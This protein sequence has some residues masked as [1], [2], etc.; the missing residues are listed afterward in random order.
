MTNFWVLCHVT[1]HQ[2]FLL[3]LH[4]IN[5]NMLT[6]W[7]LISKATFWLQGHLI[8]ITFTEVHYV[9][10]LPIIDVCTHGEIN[11]LNVFLHKSV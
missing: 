10:I 2:G 5:I 9:P 8:D 7:P 4:D 1:S 6:E 3:R 11:M